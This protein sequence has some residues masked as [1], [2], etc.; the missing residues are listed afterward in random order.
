MISVILYGRN[1]SHGYNL[2]KR[3]A[4]SLNCIAEV[5]SDPCDEILFIDYNTPN[6]LPT[7]IEAIYD[8]LTPRAKSLLRVFRIRPELHA[9]MV[10]RTHLFA[11]EPH[12]RN[13]GIRRSNP[14]NRWVLF[15][16][17]DMVFV[18][19]GDSS[20]LGDVVR[21]LADG[22]YILPRFELPEPLWEAFARSDPQAIMR[23][24]EDLGRKLHLN[25]IAIAHPY[26]RFD[27]PGD[28]QL[29]PRHALFDINGF[30]ERMIHGW[31]ADSNMCKRFYLLYGRR[32][33]SL[34]Q[35]LKGYHC[36]HTRV[37]T[38]AHRIDLKLEN[39]LQ[40][41][42]Y[43]VEDPV[44]HHQA[45]VWGVPDEPIE[46]VDFAHGPQ[47]RFTQ[48]VERVLGAPQEIDYHSDA[49]DLRNFVFYQ[50][51][52]ALPYLAGNLT[53]YPPGARFVYAGN[54]PRMLELT[55]RCITELG[56]Q[57]PLHYVRELLSSRTTPQSAKPVC[58]ADVTGGKSLHDYL[59]ANY[60]LLIFDFGLDRAGLDLGRINRVTDWPR[61]L[62]F[63]LGA[64]ARCLENCAE[65]AQISQEPKHTPEFLVLNANHFV[66]RQFVGQFLL[67]PDTPY[68]THVRKGRPRIGQE[69]LYRSHAWK[70]TE[71]YLI[72][73]FGYDAADCSV[74]AVAPGHSIDLTSSG[75]SSR[76]KDGSWGA[77]DF[78]GTWTDGTCAS[79]VFA[80]PP[81][82][83]DDLLAYVRVVEAFLGLND[84]PIC[85]QVVFEGKQLGRWIVHTRY[86]VSTSR[87]LI[88][89]A[90]MT[91][92]S[93]C[94]LEFRVENPQSTQLHATLKGEQV[95]GEDPRELGIKVQR[96]T[97]ASTDQLKYTLRQ[98]IDFREKG[99]GMYHI[100]ERWTQPDNLGTWTLGADANLV[101]FLQ[102]PVDTPVMAAFTITDVAVNDEF[103]YVNVS[104]AFNGRNVATWRLGPKRL[105]EERRVLVPLE[106]L[107][108]ENPL[109]I[110]FHV[111]SPR[112][113][114]QLKWSDSDTRQ[115]GFRLT[116]LRMDPVRA[117]KYKLGDVLDFTSAGNAAEFLSGDWTEPDRYG[118]W[119]LGERATLTVCLD[120]P[121][122]TA[123]PASFIISD[124]MVSDTAP[125][126]PVRVTANGR[127]V[128]EWVLGPSRA[129]H[130]R[131]IELPAAV[132]AA[133][134]ELTLAFEVA[135]RSP[136]SLGWS[137]TDSRPLGLRITRALFGGGEL[138]IPV[139]E[140]SRRHGSESMTRL[141]HFVTAALRG[142]RSAVRGTA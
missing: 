8:T 103:P 96:I 134:K 52:H 41:F 62:R 6:D 138:S 29:V 108:A 126:L 125:E 12:S 73:F 110:S 67:A 20:S 93:T 116:T 105:H 21:D 87:L 35:R 72:S 37:A 39:D 133:N 23:A 45:G 140:G 95:I 30:D 77:T 70:Y 117:P 69:R 44:A 124:C 11:L 2:H 15:T 27:S 56:F 130:R 82:V 107:R 43:G 25:E 53:V 75:Q 132:F 31:H 90:L 1:D 50:S 89:R 3:A 71:E 86:G 36:D 129:P 63:S 101:L 109:T 46:E 40:E 99:S 91:A 42:V 115:L 66:F 14:Q 49:N 59:L 92:K 139:F 47:A 113:P 32:T 22:Q 7:F 74:V 121:P 123:T 81:G 34:A 88:P 4:I 85:I 94:R 128:D 9:R 13:I 120:N 122:E 60:D 141:R 80:P 16:N 97:F 54:N 28:F 5:L 51:E 24:C 137:A 64:V 68:N 76:Y 58:A 83:E 33:E 135:P 131:S 38:L 106:I 104:V 55:A 17:T 119:T 102:E 57:Q 142:F 84:D 26:M 98:A 48:A 136:A 10:E 65:A 111:D 78:T 100:D 18:P 79:I 61:H 112:S 127:F 19:R 118:R 114:V